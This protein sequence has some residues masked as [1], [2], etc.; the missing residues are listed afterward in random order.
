MELKAAQDVCHALRTRLFQAQSNIE[1]M[2]RLRTAIDEGTA[3]LAFLQTDVP[4]ARRALA[5]ID[6]VLS[7][8]SP[9]RTESTRNWRRSRRAARRWTQRRTVS[10]PK[11]RPVTTR[12][13]PT[14][15]NSRAWCAPWRRMYFAL[16]PRY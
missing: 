6:T 10:R 8:T 7:I 1:T 15:S 13:S 16:C 5:E 14:Y 3:A 9:P 12:S 11:R 2:R 4:L